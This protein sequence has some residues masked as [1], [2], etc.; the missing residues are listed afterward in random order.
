MLLVV[1]YIIIFLFVISKITCGWCYSKA[2]LI[3]KTAII[4]GGNSGIGYQTALSLAS[5]G[6]RVIIV[7]KDDSS[8]ARSTIIKETDNPNIV[9]KILDLQSLKSV[10]AFAQNIIETE[11]RLD[12]LINNAGTGTSGLQYTEDGLHKTMQVNY[13]SHFLLT[14]LLLDLLKKSA[15]SRIIFTSSL[16]AFLTKLKL[17]DLNPS[18]EGSFLANFY[19]NSKLCAI[20]AAN[21]F[22]AK[23][24]GTGVTANSL[25]PGGARSRIY[26]KSFAEEKSF[27]VFLAGSLA[28]IFG[29]SCEEAAQTTIY[30]AC[31]KEIENVSGQFFIDCIKF[32]QPLQTHSKE[33]CKKVWDTSMK[34]T[35]IENSG[36]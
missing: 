27:L 2:C 34:F 16:A 19:A 26:I 12:I 14:H 25:H 32:V 28:L 1:L 30:L 23:L 31:A 24:R 11:P 10:R 33:L 29:K 13:Y 36:S 4:T 5:R 8:D 15:P 21:E 35:G 20:I 18:E 3:G 6:C 22:A 9:S 17:E 7:D